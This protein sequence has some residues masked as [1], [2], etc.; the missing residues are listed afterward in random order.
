MQITGKMEYILRTP[1]PPE[2]VDEKHRST[3]YMHLTTH[4]VPVRSFTYFRE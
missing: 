1:D 3:F 2:L 4:T